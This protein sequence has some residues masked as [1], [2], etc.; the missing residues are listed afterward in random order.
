VN[1]L[2]FE[3]HEGPHGVTHLAIIGG[4]GTLMFT[5]DPALGDGTLETP[6]DRTAALT[7]VTSLAKALLDRLSTGHPIHRT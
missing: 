1:A 2:K 4:A 6:F 5:P 3:W 7:A